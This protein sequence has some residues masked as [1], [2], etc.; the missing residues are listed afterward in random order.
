MYF[1]GIDPGQS[2][3]IA[4]ISDDLQEAY[5]W[6]YP[7]SIEAAADLLREIFLEH[8]PVLTGIEK[9]SA[10]PKQGVSS[11]FKFGQNY[12]AWLGAL[13]SLQVPFTVVTPAK[14]QKAVLDSGTGE[15]KER[16]LS[17]ARR[18]FPAVDL[19]RKKDHGKS[20]ALL[21]AVYAARWHRENGGHK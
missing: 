9:V 7:G 20:D 13:S 6:D 14:W 2:G 1:A 16:S 10:M 17:M 3:A 11:T 8:K 12:G 15:T 4:V 21:L 5:A 18:L 19:S